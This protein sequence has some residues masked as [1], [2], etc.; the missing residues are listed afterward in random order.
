M[1]FLL[2]KA[3]RTPIGILA[4]CGVLWAAIFSLNAL[5][6]EYLPEMPLFQISWLGIAAGVI[7]GFLVVMLA[8]KS[9]AKRG[10]S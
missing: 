6:S 4:G 8:S 7:I 5:N 1:L 3:W 10:H 2:E 9:P